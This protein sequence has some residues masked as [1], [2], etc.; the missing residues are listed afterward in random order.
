MRV[1]VRWAIRGKKGGDISIL[2]QVQEDERMDI[3]H[4]E[5]KKSERDNG[6]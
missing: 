3:R 4:M 6:P 5:A 2:R 1:A